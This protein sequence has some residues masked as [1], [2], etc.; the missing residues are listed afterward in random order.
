MVTSAS[1]SSW[2]GVVG[3]SGIRNQKFRKALLSQVSRN[4]SLFQCFPKGLH[5]KIAIMNCG[6]LKHDGI[7]N[8]VLAQRLKC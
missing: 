4:V 8:L 2:I 7:A 6:M 5:D 3:F 1:T